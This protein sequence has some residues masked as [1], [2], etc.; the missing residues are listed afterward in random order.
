MSTFYFSAL[1][2]W[3]STFS[4]TLSAYLVSDYYRRLYH[5]VEDKHFEQ[6]RRYGEET[7][8]RR[9]MD[10]PARFAALDYR[11][12]AASILKACASCGRQRIHCA[13]SGS[14]KSRTGE[15]TK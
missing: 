1:I 4:G 3:V 9:I 7:A 12:A 5:N 6:G 13:K 8:A 14:R 10:S 11:T 15:S 2:V